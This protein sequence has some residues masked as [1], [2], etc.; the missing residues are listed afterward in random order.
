MAE[1]RP[2]PGLMLGGDLAVLQ[3]PVFD[4]VSFDPFSL[5]D[6]GFGPTE[7]GFGRGDAVEA[8]VVALM[9]LVLDEGLDLSFALAWRK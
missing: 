6:D 7:L 1:V 2:H 9:V 3:A 8:L 5:F 4:S